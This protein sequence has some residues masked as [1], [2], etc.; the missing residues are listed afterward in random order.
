[1]LPDWR[2]TLLPLSAEPLAL[3]RALAA[4]YNGGE[5]APPDPDTSSSGGTA[6]QDVQRASNPSSNDSGGGGEVS[7]QVRITAYMRIAYDGVSHK[8]PVRPGEEGQK[9]FVSDCRR[10]L[11]LPAERD[12]DIQFYCRDPV[13]GAPVQLAGLPAY[14]AAVWCA[15]LNAASSISK[16]AAKPTPSGSAQ[17]HPGPGTAAEAAVSTGSSGGS[18]DGTATPVSGGQQRQVSLTASGNNT[19]DQPSRA[20]SS[21]STGGPLQHCQPSSPPTVMAVDRSQ[22]QQHVTVAAASADRSITAGSGSSSSGSSSAPPTVAAA[23]RPTA[24]SSA[25]RHDGN[26]TDSET[27]EQEELMPDAA[28]RRKGLSMLGNCWGVGAAAAT[29]SAA[30]LLQRLA[31]SFCGSGKQTAA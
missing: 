10:L 25:E 11:S 4:A 21:A 2:R 18:A 13:T 6:S 5:A 23:T 3:R 8:V 7:A 28:D 1:M 29:P 19:D 20:A 16:G 17:Q 14:D 9:Q 30:A 31:Q 15:M 22:G 26:S 24:S 27:H 12:F